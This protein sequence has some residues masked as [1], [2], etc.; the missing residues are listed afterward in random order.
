MKSWETIAD[1]LGKACWSWGCVSALDSVGEQSGLLTL[2]AT[3]ANV[4][5][6]AP[7]KN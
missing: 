3:T 4:S 6:C 1:N 5:L 7:M 2:I